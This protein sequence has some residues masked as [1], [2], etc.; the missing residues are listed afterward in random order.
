MTQ[1]ND[2]QLVGVKYQFRWGKTMR[3]KRDKYPA[4]YAPE[5][6]SLIPYYPQN[7]YTCLWINVC[8]D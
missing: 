7:F 4:K 2:T 6:T 1:P 3:S 5:V 8:T